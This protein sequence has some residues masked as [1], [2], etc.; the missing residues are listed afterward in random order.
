MFGRVL[1]ALKAEYLGFISRIVWE[2][3]MLQP[4]TYIKQVLADPLCNV[5][6][7]AAVSISLKIKDGQCEVAIP[8][9]ND[10]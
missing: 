10:L 5:Q 9:K 4:L 1:V 7:T 8:W 6:D 3:T 2:P